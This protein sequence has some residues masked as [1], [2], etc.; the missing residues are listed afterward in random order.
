VWHPSSVLCY[1]I[2][3][4][5]THTTFETLPVVLYKTVVNGRNTTIY[6]KNKQWKNLLFSGLISVAGSEAG[7]DEEEGPT[8]TGGGCGICGRYWC[9]TGGA[10]GG[11]SGGTEAYEEDAGE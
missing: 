2:K 9:C 11:G 3:H 10:G 7:V 5:Y 6:L 1:P 8:A 4:K